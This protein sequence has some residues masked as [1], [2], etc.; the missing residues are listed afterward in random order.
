MV[1]NF[2]ANKLRKNIKS[3]GK[4]TMGNKVVLQEKITMA[5][6]NLPVLNESNLKKNNSNNNSER[7]AEP[8]AV[9]ALSLTEY[10]KLLKQNYSAVVELEIHIFKIH[11]FQQFQK[12]TQ[13]L[14][15]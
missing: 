13:H 8:K 6:K 9:K 5:L 1:T 4:P 10:H 2:K 3:W 15:Q 11:T 14:K 7:Q 12:R